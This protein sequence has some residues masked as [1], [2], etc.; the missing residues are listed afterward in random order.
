M[1]SALPLTTRAKLAGSERER[2]NVNSPRLTPGKLPDFGDTAPSD[3]I[4][5]VNAVEEKDRKNRILEESCDGKNYRSKQSYDCEELTPQSVS[6][7]RTACVS[8]FSCFFTSTAD[9]TTHVD[10]S[11]QEDN[12]SEPSSTSTAG[13]IGKKIKNLTLAMPPDEGT[14][15]SLIGLSVSSTSEYLLP[16]ITETDEGRKCLILDLD[17]TLVHSSFQPMACTFALP[18][19]IK[20]TQYKVYVRVRPFV[21]EFLRECAKHFELVIFT[22][23]MSDYANPVIDTIDKEGVIKY[24]LF[25]ESCIQH[26]RK[27]YI[28]DLSRLGRDLKN[29]IIIDNSSLSYMFNPRNAIGCKTWLGDKKDSELRDLIPVLESLR[30]INDVREVLNGNAQNSG[31]LISA[32]GRSKK[33]DNP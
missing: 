24:R 13:E 3:L 25:R 19:D 22:A 7:S 11:D 18:L 21:E 23:S 15:D 27:F 12:T 9:V 31:W 2:M 6:Q 1:T 17:E 10:E 14:E 32:F 33:R 8:C 26:E 30:R 20:G 5:Q 29:C 28:K 4:I 16:P